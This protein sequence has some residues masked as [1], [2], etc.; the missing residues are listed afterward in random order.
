VPAAEDDR[1]PGIDPTEEP[2][3]DPVGDPQPAAD[4]RPQ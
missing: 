3:I 4:R 2:L 1:P